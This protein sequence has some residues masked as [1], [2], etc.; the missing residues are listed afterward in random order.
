[1]PGWTLS[2]PRSTLSSVATDGSPDL[3]DAI[4]RHRGRV[5]GTLVAFAIALR[6]LLAIDCPTPFGYVFDYYH[7][8]VE[9][10][11]QNGR[12]PIAEDCW[13]CYHPPLY[14]AA[15]L[16]FYA[17]GRWLGGTRESAPEW[18]LRGLTGLAVV[19]GALTAWF[20]L[21]AVTA[22]VD[23]P[24][25]ATVGAALI[26]ASPCLFISS[27]GPDADVVE[28]AAMTAFLASFIPFAAA[29]PETRTWRSAATVGALAGLAAAA[30]YSGLIAL[31]TA[32]IVLGWQMLTGPR[33]SRTL[34]LALLVA[35]VA[36]AVGGFKYVDNARRYGTPLYANGSAGDA[37]S[38]HRE[39]FWDDYDFLSFHPSEILAVSGPN[40]PPGQLTELP[41][42][43]SVWTT[44][45]GM[46]WGDLS[47]FSV[48]GRI[49]DPAAPYPAKSI[50]R[51]LIGSVV[52]LGLIPTLLVPIGIVARIRRREYLPMLVMLVVTMASYLAWVVA[53]DAW[54]LK[55]KYLLFLLPICVAYAMAGLQWLRSVTRPGS[56][57]ALLGLLAL[58]AVA[59][60]YLYAFAVGRI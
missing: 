4:A 6:V 26:F 40:A 3:L 2:L 37:L 34:A 25:I 27:Y 30:K 56:R 35:A 8:G 16:P 36:I 54:A 14:Y 41:V 47:F 39:Y 20:S 50:P 1:M 10:M 12:L 33:R 29:R 15:G 31:A 53:Q 57:L 42:Y 48:P 38:T 58:I 13:Q 22:V 45:Y 51:T 5:L 17:V 32:G 43:H 59:H 24:A 60:L 44:L 28:A 23:D 49:D 55:A 19:A 46:A 9:L 18:G 21:Q 11:Y 52:Y 7:E